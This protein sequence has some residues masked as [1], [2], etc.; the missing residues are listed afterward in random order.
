MLMEFLFL[1]FHSI[2]NKILFYHTVYLLCI[3]FIIRLIQYLTGNNVRDSVPAMENPSKNLKNSLSLLLKLMKPIGNMTALQ[4]ILRFIFIQSWWVIAF[5]LIC[6][7]FY[8][9]GLKERNMLYQQL[10]QKLAS[11]QHEKQQTLRE[12]QNLQLQINSQSDLAWIELTLM[13]GLGLVP[14]G[15]Q[16][17]Y[18]F[19][20]ERCSPHHLTNNDERSLEVSY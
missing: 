3:F 4:Q 17:V 2:S 8:E 18:F 9:Q 1:I 13:K 14:E 15:H 5:V 16:K 12:Q 10:D 20:D 19:P 11:L 6:T 7:I